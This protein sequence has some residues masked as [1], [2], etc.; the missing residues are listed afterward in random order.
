MPSLLPLPSDLRSF[1]SWPSADS[2]SSGPSEPSSESEPSSSNS[3]TGGSPIGTNRENCSTRVPR[4]ASVMY[5]ARSTPATSGRRPGC[6]RGLDRVAVVGADPHRG[7]QRRGEAR[8]S[9]RPCS[10]R[11]RGCCTVPVL[12]ATGRSPRP[13]RANPATSSIA[14]VTLRATCWGMAC[15]PVRLAVGRRARRRRRWSPS[16]RRA[17]GGAARRRPTWRRR[18]PCRSDAPPG[19]RAGCRRGV[20]QQLLRGCRPGARPSITR[21]GP[22]V[23]AHLVEDR[24]DRPGH[25][26]L[27]RALPQ[28]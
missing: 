27:H 7:R 5:G 25:R 9:T 3:L 18:Q 20:G 16:R 1:L 26:G 15:W 6:R 17:G 14:S 4:S 24:V 28:S 19:R 11:P 12:A 21:A 13:I 8:P 10:A 2:L 22:D 23:E